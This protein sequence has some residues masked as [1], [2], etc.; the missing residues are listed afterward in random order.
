MAGKGSIEPVRR[1]SFRALLWLAVPAVAAVVLLLTSRGAPRMPGDGDHTA[2][3]SEVRCLSCHSF[4]GERPR[5]DDHPPRDDCFSCHALAD[6]AMHPR[7][8][9]PTSLPGGWRDAPGRGVVT[10]PEA[11]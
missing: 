8:G 1:R 4:A 6:G 7:P 3:T 11:L 2:R 9:A 10:P 5:P